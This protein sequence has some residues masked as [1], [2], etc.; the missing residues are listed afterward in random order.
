MSEQKTKK[1]QPLIQVRDMLIEFGNG[2]KKFKAVK[3]VTFDVKTGETFGLV[4]ESGSGKT[5]VARAIMGMQ[6]IRDGA[7]Y[8]DGVLARGKRPNLF[9][10]AKALERNLEILIENQISTTLKID[11]FVNEYKR[12]YYK[13]L[14]SKYYDLKTGELRSYPDGFDRKIPEG[15][16]LKNTKIVTADKENILKQIYLIVA[17]SLKRLVKLVRILQKTIQFVDNLSDYID[18]DERLDKTIS[19]Y[20]KTSKKKILEVKEFENQVYFALQDLRKVRRSV[21][22]GECNSVQKFFDDQG[23]SIKLMIENHKQIS[24]VIKSLNKDIDFVQALVSPAKER[25]NYVKSLLKT[26]DRLQE[27]LD[28]GTND[29]I[30]KEYQTVIDLLNLKN[31]NEVLKESRNFAK[32]TRADK[33]DLKRE[34][35]MIFQD[36]SSSLNDRMAVEEIIGEG[37]N[38]FPELYNS[39]E[40]VDE[41]IK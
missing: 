8:F 21:K 4:G 25:Q 18:L 15:V 1:Q 12:I 29:K 10:L 2:R 17:D 31:I 24:G 9:R 16:N 34:M 32:P 39:Q 33:K 38:N 23:H 35:Q 6:P 27:S 30:V 5:T 26:I 40:A 20:L 41:Y 11:E 13:Y 3:G 36:P 14:T 37:L 7:V 19:K 28:E 22:L